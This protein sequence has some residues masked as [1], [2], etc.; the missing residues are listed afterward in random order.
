MALQTVPEQTRQNTCYIIMVMSETHSCDCQQKRQPIHVLLDGGLPLHSTH[1]NSSDLLV[2][3]LLLLE[4]TGNT[5][6]K[7]TYAASKQL[8]DSLSPA[9]HGCSLQGGLCF[10][11]WENLQEATGHT[12]VQQ[13]PFLPSGFAVRKLV[14]GATK[15]V[16]LVQRTS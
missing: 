5:G 6:F 15:H 9:M 2:W 10:P 14:H 8:Y 1:V 7:C 13:Q 12:Y 16:S 3:H 11:A 4:T